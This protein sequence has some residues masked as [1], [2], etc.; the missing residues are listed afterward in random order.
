M[1]TYAFWFLQVFEVVTCFKTNSSN[2]PLLSRMS[3]ADHNAPAF[4]TEV[5]NLNAT[6]RIVAIFEIA[7]A[8]YL[9]QGRF[10]EYYLKPILQ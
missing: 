6:N 9:N 7:G 10:H 8:L 1:P 5:A 4:M 2:L 3:A